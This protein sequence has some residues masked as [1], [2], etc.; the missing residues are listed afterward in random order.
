VALALQTGADLDL[1]PVDA[2]AGAN[3]Q[4][5]VAEDRGPAW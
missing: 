4:P 1:T 2:L 5:G 3:H